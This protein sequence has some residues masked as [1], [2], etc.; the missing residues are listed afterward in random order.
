MKFTLLAGAALAAVFAA[1]GASAQVV[2]GWYG[3]V[4]VGWHRPEGIE[5]T[6]A[7]NSPD[8]RP[9]E[10]T[11]DSQEDWVGFARLGYR[12]NPN[13]RVELEGGYRPSEMG[14][15]RG[16]ATRVSGGS[17]GI[18]SVNVLRTASNPTCQDPYGTISSIT[19][20]VNVIYDFNFS[21]FQGIVPFV[22][23]GLGLNFVDMELVGQYGVVPGPT[24]AG[25]PR[26]QNLLIDDNDVTIA[27]QALAGLTWNATDRLALDLT[28]RY[29]SGSDLTFDSRSSAA[30]GNGGFAGS[31]GLD[32]GAFSGSYE[33]TSITLGVRYAFAPP[34]PPPEPAPLP[35]PPVETPPPYVP[36]PAETPP[37]PPPPQAREFIVY[38]PFDQSILTPE[39][40]T[41]VQEAASYA[42]QGNATR[43]SVVGH[44]DT[45]GSAAYNVRLSERRARA[46]ADAMVGLGVNAGIITADWRGES[47]PAVATGDGVKEPLNRRATIDIGF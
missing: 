19:T 2:N 36:P 18:C 14:P 44:A 41:V 43:I 38:F 30:P 15:V 23:A 21:W 1:S 29:L 46:V 9:F 47:Q 5:A 12:I 22:G 34:P 37:P 20:M 16:D 7:N 24:T 26:F 11:F 33:D 39:A 6:S 31:A 13:W 27:W 35:P 40:Q 4:D 17:T 42:Q 8:G 3:A 10:F 32:P 28:Y 45:S 25:N